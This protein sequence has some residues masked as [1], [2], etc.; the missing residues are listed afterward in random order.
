MSNDNYL[1]IGNFSIDTNGNMYQNQTGGTIKS[2]EF[3]FAYTI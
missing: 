2:G 3:S 1:K